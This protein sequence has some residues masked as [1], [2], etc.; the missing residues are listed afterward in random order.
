MVSFGLQYYTEIL[1]WAAS[2]KAIHADVV[3]FQWMEGGG[4][5]Y[6]AASPNEGAIHSNVNIAS[7]QTFC[8]VL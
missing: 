6:V 1:V 7:R 2:L 3:H 5:S 8:Q 4:G